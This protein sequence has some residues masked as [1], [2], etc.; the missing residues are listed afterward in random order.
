MNSLKMSAMFAAYVWFTGRKSESA[1]T[2]KEAMSFARANWELFLPDAHDGLGRL[3]IRIARARK[4]RMV[5]RKRTTV[6]VAG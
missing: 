6:T 3:L 4:R 5:G 1:K 2:Q